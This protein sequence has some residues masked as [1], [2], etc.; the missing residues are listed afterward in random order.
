MTLVSTNGAESCSGT[1]TITCSVALA[2]FRAA[3]SVVIAARATQSGTFTNHATVSAAAPDIDSANNSADAT[4]TV[5]AGPATADLSIAVSPTSGQFTAGGTAPFTVTVTN[6]GPSE[7]VR[8]RVGGLAVPIGISPGGF[9]DAWLLGGLPC[10]LDPGKTVSIKSGVGSR[11]P[12][13]Y[14]TELSVSSDTPDPNSTND[15]AQTTFTFVAPGTL[16]PAA[17]LAVSMTASPSAVRVGH[18]LTYSIGVEN[19]GP[20]DAAGVVLSSPLRDGAAFDSVSANQGSCDATVVCDLGSLAKGATANVTIVVRPAIW[21]VKQLSQV[22]QVSALTV[23]PATI[24]GDGGPNWASTTVNVIPAASPPLVL[25]GDAKIAGFTVS[26]DATPAAALDAFGWIGTRQYGEFCDIEAA[27]VGITLTFMG[28][29]GGDACTEGHFRQAVI[30]PKGVRVPWRTDRGL[31]L[32]DN[33]RKLRRLY[34]S[35]RAHGRYWWLI[36]RPSPYDPGERFPGLAAR[37]VAGRVVGFL[38]YSSAGR[39]L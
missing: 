34:P 5:T 2:P 14:T 11:A 39:I 26:A 15:S 21:W 23:D 24:P 10:V 4:T 19:R 29:L 3:A 30:A 22:V 9:C 12:G 37:V 31:R 7:A 13:T 36:R 17:D 32:G 1:T 28:R 38:V 27:D 18:R 25:E 8:P 35:A 6:N 16:Q 20:N 33:V